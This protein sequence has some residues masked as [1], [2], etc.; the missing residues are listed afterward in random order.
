MLESHSARNN[1]IIETSTHNE[2]IIG[3]NRSFEI[4]M[5]Y[6]GALLSCDVPKKYA[7]SQKVGD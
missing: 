1:A 5:V 6:V 3:F 2:T 4:H 7:N